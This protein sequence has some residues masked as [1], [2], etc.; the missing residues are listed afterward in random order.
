M[1]RLAFLGT[2]K[3]L[4]LAAAALVLTLAG[5]AWLNRTPLLTWYYLRGLADAGEADREKW[6]ERLAGLDGA[7]VPGL[8]AFLQEGSPMVCGNAG[9]ALARL[10]KRWG[11][12][13]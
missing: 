3:G 10:F 9:A 13:D 1:R 8:L 12:E 4:L 5:L 6:V 2:K 7:A 11:A